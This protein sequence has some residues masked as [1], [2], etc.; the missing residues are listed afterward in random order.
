MPFI[1]CVA[2]K[3]AAERK[4][5]FAALDFK[6]TIRKRLSKIGG[7][8]DLKKKIIYKSVMFISVYIEPLKRAR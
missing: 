6:C 3:D 5:S 7:E 4:H 1:H 8:I 2:N